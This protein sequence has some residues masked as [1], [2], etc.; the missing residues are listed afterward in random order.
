MAVD[1]G[2]C[3]AVVYRCFGQ[4]VTMMLLVITLRHIR[5]AWGLPCVF[6]RLLL[7]PE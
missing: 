6:V 3:V 7:G 5:H 2:C 1:L 4:A